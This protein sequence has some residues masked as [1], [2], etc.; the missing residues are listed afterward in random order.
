MDTKEFE[1]L[2]KEYLDLATPELDEEFQ[3][4]LALAEKGL[5][6]STRGSSFWSDLKAK[7][8][9]GILRNRDLGSVTIGMI[10]SEV[11]SK[12]TA[13][14]LDLQQYKLVIV[15]FIAVVSKAVWD[16]LEE[17][18]NKPTGQP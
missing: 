17:R 6:S 12:I 13:A 16:T 10:T 7:I 14:G 1:A 5:G 2:A 9:A 4:Q 18:P 11:L 15:V 8:V 3:K